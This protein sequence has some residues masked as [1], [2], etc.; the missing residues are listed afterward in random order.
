M[1]E[2]IECAIA[3]APAAWPNVG[4]SKSDNCTLQED[5]MYSF[6]FIIIEKLTISIFNFYRSPS[7][8][9]F[10]MSYLKA[11]NAFQHIRKMIVTPLGDI[12]NW[13]W[14]FVLSN[15]W[16][17]TKNLEI[18]SDLSNYYRCRII[19]AVTWYLGCEFD[20]SH[21]IY[22]SSQNIPWK[23]SYGND[24]RMEM[25]ASARL[26]T[27]ASTLIGFRRDNWP[28]APVVDKINNGVF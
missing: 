11:G 21:F 3:R 4:V 18:F 28:L 16:T 19:R 1:R 24:S 2:H 8:I 22:S 10:S 9:Q 13:L 7:L 15:H 6:A 25:T 17:A 27:E 23:G 20:F 26:T 12:Y 5:D 14:N